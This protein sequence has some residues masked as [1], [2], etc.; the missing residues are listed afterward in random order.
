MEKFIGA[1][2]I[3]AAAL[4]FGRCCIQGQRR[5]LKQLLQW[6]EYIWMIQNGMEGW[7]TPV[8]P[9]LEELGNQADEP[10]AVFFRELAIT[11]ENY[12]ESDIVLQW[13]RIAKEKRKD[14]DW[15]PGEWETF[16]D[17]GKLFARSDKEMIG[18]EGAQLSKRVDFFI[19]QVQ[20]DAGKRERM[21]LALSASAG[22]MLILL[23]I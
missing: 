9:L 14:F 4:G 18:R 3:L 10:F 16:L 21:S 13:R 6:K 15:S 8:I 5:H 17:G 22:I 1:V 12:S 7:N 23:L 20:S 11:L 2:I 19:D